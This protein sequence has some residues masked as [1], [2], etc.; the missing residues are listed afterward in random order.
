MRAH[1][2]LP[3]AALALSLAC[4]S[5]LKPAEAESALRAQYPVTVL[6]KLPAQAS[7]AKGSTQAAELGSLKAAVEQSGWFKA[8]W[9]EGKDR[10]EIALTPTASAPKEMKPTAGGFLAP[11][12]LAAF[13]RSLSGL[14]RGD[15]ARVRYQIR[16]ERP[17]PLFP[18]F[19]Q[20][21]PGTHVGGVH[22]R[23][24]VFRRSGSTWSFVSSDEKYQKAE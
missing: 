10:V 7:A 15:E 4:S 9:K 8:E 12:A 3:V 23:T 5:K 24:A 17:T 13:D 2:L 11:V 6:M 16:L 1:L 21:H 20:K 19:E 22:G 14:T 18:L